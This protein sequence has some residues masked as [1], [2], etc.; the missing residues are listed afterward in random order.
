MQVPTKT[1]PNIKWHIIL[2]L[3]LATWMMLFGVGYAAA[4][5]ICAL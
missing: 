4:A 5:L 3:G 2:P 1:H